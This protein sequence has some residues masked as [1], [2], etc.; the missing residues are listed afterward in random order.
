[1]R[2]FLHPSLSRFKDL[3]DNA[4]RAA[5]AGTYTLEDEDYVQQK[6]RSII[7]CFLS[8][9]VPPKVQVGEINE[10]NLASFSMYFP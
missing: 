6:A 8:S 7:D 3:A 2:C 4:A 9:Q 10:D 5:A 1:M